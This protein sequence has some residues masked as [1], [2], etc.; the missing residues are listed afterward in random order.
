ML[1]QAILACSEKFNDKLN[2]LGLSN[3][4]ITDIFE[5]MGKSTFAL[6]YFVSNYISPSCDIKE[7]I[8]RFSFPFMRRCALLWKLLNSSTPAPFYD[9]GENCG[10]M[11][12]ESSHLNAEVIGHELEINEIHEL[13]IMFKIPSLDFILNDK[14]VR[15][16]VLKWFHHLDKDYEFRSLGNV[17]YVTPAVPF[18]LMEL[19]HLYQD[20]LQRFVLVLLI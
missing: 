5:A 4:L 12:Y 18:K 13:E 20:L 19:P 7:T 9:G 8:R 11:M 6:Q 2:E 10:E 16:L 15:S 1:V 3:C 17:M 14:G